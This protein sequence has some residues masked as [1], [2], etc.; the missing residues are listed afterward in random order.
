MKDISITDEQIN[1][2]WEI[3]R[4]IIE[5][6]NFQKLKN[7]YAHKK[8]TIYEHCISVAKLS[9]LKS[10][11]KKNID[12]VSLIRGALLHDYYFYD[13]HKNKPFTFHGYKHPKIA[14]QN[15][16]RDFELNEKEKNII[17]SHMFPLT[18][19]HFPKCSEAWI[20]TICDKKIAKM[21]IRGEKN[22]IYF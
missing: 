11:T 10:L 22:A 5:S 2:F 12:Y 9:F 20:V 16:C 1:Q 18:L 21:E 7:F 13:W 14:E 19:F 15:A 4:P 8:T 3:A 6:E 17:R